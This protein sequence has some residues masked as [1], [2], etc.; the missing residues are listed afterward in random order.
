[1]FKRNKKSSIIVMLAALLMLLPLSG[2]A[3]SITRGK[4]Q[5]TTKTSTSPK[6]KDVKSSS[7]NKTTT[8]EKSNKSEST[9]KA[10]TKATVHEYVD[11]GLSVKWA[12][13]NIGAN[14]PEDVGDY[15]AWGETSVKYS[16]VEDNYRWYHDGHYELP[17]GLSDIAGSDYDVAHVKWG[18]KW[19][20]PTLYEIKE[21]TDNCTS[22]FTT[23]NGISGRLITGPNGKSI[24][25][26]AGGWIGDLETPS[27]TGLL[28]M[29]RSSQK[30][31]T[32]EKWAWYI[33]SSPEKLS[34]SYD[35]PRY[36]GLNVR[37]VCK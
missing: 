19:R 21:L 22:T 4:K 31:V 25:I 17:G 9:K 28:C 35:I 2:T 37:P 13:C 34:I 24:F 5:Q 29:I 23:I 33:F 8:K 12:T 1:M 6:K 20:L 27:F 7:K 30:S 26:P 15:Y 3:Q 10:N 11:L 14:S 18:G 32:E 16:Y 36:Y